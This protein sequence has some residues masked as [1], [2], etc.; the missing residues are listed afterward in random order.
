M[1]EQLPGGFRYI[2]EFLTEDEA[3]LLGRIVSPAK[4]VR[5]R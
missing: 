5:D 1:D 4:A 2:P 3:A